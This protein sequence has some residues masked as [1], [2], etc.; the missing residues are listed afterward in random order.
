MRRAG[1]AMRSIR[2]SRPR[3]VRLRRRLAADVRGACPAHPAWMAG[4]GVLRAGVVAVRRAQHGAAAHGATAA[5]RRRGTACRL[6]LCRLARRSRG[7]PTSCRARGKAWTSR[8]SASST[9]SRANS[10][11]GARFAFAVERVRTPR[12]VVPA[13]VVAGL[14]RAARVP[15][16]TSDD[17]PV[18]HAG[19]RWHLTVRL[20]RPHGTVNPGGFDLEA[21]LLQQGL[22]RDGLRASGGAQRAPRRVRRRAPATTCSAR[23]S[24]FAIASSR[25]LPARRMPA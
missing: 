5:C 24:A 19:E 2:R 15:A 16:P 10:P 23:A 20:K 9:T 6:R 8:S 22:A 18:V 21:W 3:G 17:V 13:R 1:I 25:R 12:A 11:Q 4:A 14:V 7:W